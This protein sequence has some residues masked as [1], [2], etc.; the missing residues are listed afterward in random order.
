MK[1]GDIVWIY[2]DPV[3][4]SKP[5]GQAKLLRKIDEGHSQDYWKVKFL[6]DGFV[7]SRWVEKG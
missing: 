6:L 7:T 3:V 2:E 4:K 5:E 1:I